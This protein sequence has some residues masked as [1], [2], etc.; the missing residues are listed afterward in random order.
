[1]ALPKMNSKEYVMGL[2]GVESYRISLKPT[3]S[4][5]SY[6][7]SDQV[8]FGIP[9]YSFSSIN[10]ARTYLQFKIRAIGADRQHAVFA[11][12]NQVFNKLVVKNDSGNQL[13]DIQRYE[14]FSRLMDNLKTKQQIE[15]EA[16]LS[17]D[18]RVVKHEKACTDTT[19]YSFYHTVVHD[20]KSGVLGNTQKGLV[21]LDIMRA[22]S[23]SAYTVELTLA[24]ALTVFPETRAGLDIQYEITDCTL[25]LEMLRIPEEI[26]RDI[27]ADLFKT[28]G[29]MLPYK[30]F[31]MAR[32]DVPDSTSCNLQISSSKKDVT[33]IYSILSKKTKGRTQIPNDEANGVKSMYGE[34]DHQRFLG[35]RYTYSGGVITDSDTVVTQYNFRYANRSFPLSPVIM[36]GDSTLAL[37]NVISTFEM[38]EKLPYASEVVVTAINQLIPLFETSTFMMAQNF[39]SYS[40]QRVLNGLNIAGMG[41]PLEVNIQFKDTVSDLE[42]VAFLEYSETLYIGSGGMSTINKPM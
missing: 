41:A 23:G 10:T 21:N 28:N 32:R 36:D 20:L 33:G 39:K 7:E 25:E 19:N 8:I 34:A 6:K 15:G 4:S 1:M 16:S 11:G 24:S 37:A 31:T 18:F 29:S 17:K 26:Q 12:A 30:T 9:S 14:T 35:G 38:K 42:C 3:N 40:D 22:S 2:P 13:E 5:G 27:N